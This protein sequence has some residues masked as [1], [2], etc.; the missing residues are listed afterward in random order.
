[1]AET[2]LQK[3]D[4]PIRVDIVIPVFN[5]EVAVIAFHQQL[6]QVIDSLINFQFSIVYVNDGSTDNT[7]TVLERLAASDGRVLV[8]ELSRN[9]GQQ[10]ALTAGLDHS[11][12]Q[13]VITMD[14]DGQHP[15]DL[16]P[17]MLR[18][19]Q[20]GYDVVLTQR[21]EEHTPIFKNVTSRLFYRFINFIGDTH[22][23]PG[24][25]DFRLLTRPVVQSLQSM[26]E[27]HRLLRGMVAWIGYRSVIVP[28]KQPKRLGGESKYSLSRLLRLAVDAVFSFS[29][30]P[31]YLG[32]SVGA[33]FLALALAEMIYV[34]SFWVTGNQAGLAPGWSSLMFVLLVVGGSIMIMLGFVG[35]YI[36]FI[37]Q[38]VKQRPIYITRSKIGGQVTN[39]IADPT[40]TPTGTGEPATEPSARVKK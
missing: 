7:Q 33:I 2:T 35:V 23:E 20:S 18:L 3:A 13:Y 15:P 6:S 11:N 34:L 4:S 27:Y 21:V 24:A 8:L 17:E 14:G 32:I 12:G 31:L 9:F 36:G 19:A 5:E 38:E 22:I 29:L 40:S 16:V 37:F 26:R 25:P 10:A 28:Y 1:M 39:P 30:V